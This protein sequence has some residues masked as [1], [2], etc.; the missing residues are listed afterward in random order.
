[1]NSRAIFRPEMGFYIGIFWPLLF[2]VLTHDPCPFGLP[3]MLTMAHL[4]SAVIGL[5]RALDLVPS[6]GLWP[7]Y[8]VE[9]IIWY[10]INHR[11]EGWALT[12]RWHIMDISGFQIRSP[13]LRS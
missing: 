6:V 3:E 13:W 9:T 5:K 10:S 11:F 2:Q 1:M 8:L 7:M 12:L 4:L